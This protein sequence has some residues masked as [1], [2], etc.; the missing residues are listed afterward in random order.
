MK[1][2]NLTLKRI[3]SKKITDNHVEIKLFDF[4]IDI[5][6][7]SIFG[8]THVHPITGS[9][10]VFCRHM[11]PD[12]VKHCGRH[13]NTVQPNKKKRIDETEWTK[14]VNQVL[15]HVHLDIPTPRKVK[16]V[17]KGILCKKD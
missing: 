7:G 9:R 6:N 3:T 2:T 8:I 10:A 12:E 5:S 16:K 15:G 14:L 4:E 1:R 11:R 17:Q 13:F